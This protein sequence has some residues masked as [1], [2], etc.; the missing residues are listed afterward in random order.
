MSIVKI[1]N[2]IS[3]KKYLARRRR[4]NNDRRVT[5]YA[6]LSDKRARRVIARLTWLSAFGITFLLQPF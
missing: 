1:L 6:S 4:V 2:V 5:V 3:P